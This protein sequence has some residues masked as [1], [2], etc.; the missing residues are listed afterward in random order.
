MPIKI[1]TVIPCGTDFA[2]A[3]DISSPEIF[4]NCTMP[5]AKLTS[6]YLIFWANIF[7]KITSDASAYLSGVL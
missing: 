6:A 3:S 2:I 5:D 7:L 1:F 4:K